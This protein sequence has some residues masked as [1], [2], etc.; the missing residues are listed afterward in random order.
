MSSTAPL[1]GHERRDAERARTDRR[2]GSRGVQPSTRVCTEGLYRRSAPK[3]CTADLHGAGLAC[4]AS[5]RDLCTRPLCKVL[6][7]TPAQNLCAAVRK[8][9]TRRSPTGSRWTMR[10]DSPCDTSSATRSRQP[11]PGRSLPFVRPRDHDVQAL[12]HGADAL[13]PSPPD[14]LAALRPPQAPVRRSAAIRPHR[15]SSDGGARLT[16]ANTAPRRTT[17]PDKPR[18]PPAPPTAQR[19]RHLARSR[20]TRRPRVRNAQ[21]RTASPDSLIAALS[22]ANDPSEKASRTC[23]RNAAPISHTSARRTDIACDPNRTALSNDVPEPR[24]PSR[25]KATR[26]EPGNGFHELLQTCPFR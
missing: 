1:A 3:V 8:R 4:R 20:S 6:R 22:R 16:A 26:Q 5:A 19:R 9:H 2:P 12:I 18:S 13:R 25:H 17:S 14:S 15:R 24:Q 23:I 7:S 21:A 11:T 10:P